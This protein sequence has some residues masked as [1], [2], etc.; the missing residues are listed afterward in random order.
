MIH[1]NGTIA[2]AERELSFSYFSAQGPGGQHVNRAATAVQLRFDA[3]SSP[4]LTAEV[5]ER[6]RRVAGR[7][8]TEDGVVI[9]RAQRFRSQDMNRQDAI[10]RL[11]AMLQRAARAP[12]ARR[13]TRP[14][15]QAK[16]RRLESKHRRATVKR[17]RGT[18]RGDD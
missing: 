16:E 18:P 3:A 15:R 4:S 5:V 8:M 17:S 7:R 12:T 2:I 9:V 13:P 6:L 10:D 14:S 11:V 1:V